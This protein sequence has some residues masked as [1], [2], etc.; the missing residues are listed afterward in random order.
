MTVFLDDQEQPLNVTRSRVAAAQPLTS[1]HPSS[2]ARHGR[3]TTTFLSLNI[4]FVM[5]D[6]A[7]VRN[8]K[9]HRAPMNSV[10]LYVQD[11]VVM[12]FPGR[13]KLYKGDTLVIEGQNLNLAA[14]ESDIRVL[15]GTHSCNVTSLAL[16]Q[17]VCSPPAVQ[18]PGTDDLG[19]QTPEGVPLVVVRVGENLR[20]PLG[21]LRYEMIKPYTFPP[22]VVGGIAASGVF[23]VLL[24]VV[25]LVV[26]RRKSTQAER[27]YKRIQI[28]MDTLESNVRMECKQAFAELQTDITDLT[29]DLESTGIPIFDHRTF[30]MKVFFPGVTDHP[31][32]GDPKLRLNGTRTN[33]DTAMQQFEQL[34]NNRY[35]LLTFIEV[36]ESQKSFS[37][38]DK[39]NTLQIASEELMEEKIQCRVLD[40]DTISQVKSKIL[41]A[42]YK[43][44]PHSLRPSI[45]EVDLEWRH[46]R[47]GHLTLADEDLTSKMVDGWRRINTLA[48]YGVKDSCHTSVYSIPTSLSPSQNGTI[49]KVNAFHLV[50]P[51]CEYASQRSERSHKAIPEIFLTRLLSTK[52]TIQKFVDDLLA[53][54]LNAGETL[55]P[56]IKWLFDPVRLR[57]RAY[58]LCPT[59]M[60][61]CM[62]GSPTHYQLRFWVN[63]I[64]NPDFLFD[65]D[66]SVTVDSSL[67]VIAQTFMDACSTSE[68]RL[69]K[70][71]TVQQAALRQGP[72]ALPVSGREVLPRHQRP[73]D[74]DRPGAQ[75]T[76][77]EALH[78]TRRQFDVIAALKEL[79]IYVTKYRDDV[80]K[81]LDSD[82]HCRRLHLPHKLENV[83]S[84][85]EGEE[86]SMC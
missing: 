86:T 67:T 84:T 17:L 22:E 64:K 36:L 2:P 5:D 21:L 49:R 51:A 9:Q 30:V 37:I 18:P 78:G 28:Q 14:D 12:P 69:G 61:W 19:R 58:T 40:C 33:F 76:H 54:I 43:N 56:A 24:S 57:P 75:L 70:D 16:S 3:P 63:F 55:P 53:T 26:Y 31:I 11:P 8:L 41:D 44:T 62:R 79:Y 25:I 71:S 66:K 35:F 46:G 38:R 45:H 34:I 13:V 65:I 81:A 80:M 32:L 48:H 10:L 6:V 74:G 60:R 85:M 39:V 20:F 42:L 52:G 83:Q 73:A 29:A 82:E 50:K 1:L 59:Q 23:L 27:E 68:H 72:A 77:A 4:G 7:S 15:I 47:G